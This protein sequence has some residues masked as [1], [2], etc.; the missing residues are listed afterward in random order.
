MNAAKKAGGTG[1]VDRLGV[2]WNFCKLLPEMLHID[3]MRQITYP[4]TFV[5]GKKCPTST[6]H[7]STET[8]LQVTAMSTFIPLFA[9]FFFA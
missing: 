5:R 3:R 6:L 4:T 7:F 9:L 1:R 2:A 8:M